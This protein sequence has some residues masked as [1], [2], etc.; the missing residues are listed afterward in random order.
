MLRNI[1]ITTFLKTIIIFVLS[2]I[3]I[4]LFSLGK[5]TFGFYINPI[6]M[7]IAGL[8]MAVILLLPTKETTPNSLS[9]SVAT[10][11]GIVVL[12][13][14]GIFYIGQR[15][16]AEFKAHPIDHNESDVLA[17]VLTPSQAILDGKDAYQLVKLPSYEMFNT[18]LP[19][20]WS[21]F[22]MAHLTGVDARWIPFGAWVA[23]CSWIIG[24]YLFRSQGFSWM[25]VTMGII[26]WLLTTWCFVHFYSYDFRVTLEL[27]P[28]SYYVLLLFLMVRAKH[29]GVGIVF[30]FCLLSRFT[31]VLLIPFLVYYYWKMYGVKATSS[32]VL[33]TA[34]VILGL[35]V[36][37]FMSK[38]S[39]LPF[40]IMQNY[41]NG[42]A[43]EWR[44]HAWQNPGDE[45][46]QLSRG[47]GLAIFAKK[48]YEWDVVH[49]VKRLRQ[50]GLACSILVSVLL[51]GYMIYMGDHRSKDHDQLIGGFKLFLTVF[52]ALV[53]IP[54]PYLFVLPLMMNGV[55]LMVMDDENYIIN[56][57]YAS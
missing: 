48:H 24:F 46:H 31:I 22:V 5:Q 35:F 21:P 1:A 25:N 49:G 54:Y 6:L 10:R 23:V 33:M 53:L 7:T 47:L 57:I 11:I 45:P 9:S 34:S 55:Y 52:Y 2:L 12:W 17:Q 51:I 30:G 42:S 27:L 32:V 29:I 3:E 4:Y 20:M 19:M 56:H 41:T 36:I 8:V 13:L 26:V 28:I 38:D 44:T 14:I 18:Y 50:V 15:I 43:G 16:Q 40:K 39:Q 37:P